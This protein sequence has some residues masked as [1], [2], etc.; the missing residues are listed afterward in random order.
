MNSVMITVRPNLPNCTVITGKFSGEQIARHWKDP[1]FERLI[2]EALKAAGNN[3][4]TF[5]LA[6]FIYS[7]VLNQIRRRY[8]KDVTLVSITAL[9]EE[10]NFGVESA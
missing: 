8:G 10:K 2:L 3:K 4:D 5:E 7:Y 6:N 9:D 1:A